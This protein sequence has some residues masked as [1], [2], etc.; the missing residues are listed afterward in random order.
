MSVQ[1]LSQSFTT[2]RH[3]NYIINKVDLIKDKNQS[4][5]AMDIKNILRE[6]KLIDHKVLIFYVEKLLFMCFRPFK[7]VQHSMYP[8]STKARC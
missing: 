3:L 7:S 2:E 4:L 1:T 8:N 5:N 6:T